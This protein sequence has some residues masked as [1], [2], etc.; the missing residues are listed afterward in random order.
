MRIWSNIDRSFANAQWLD[1]FSDVIIERLDKSVSDHCPQLLKFDQ[2]EVKRR[3]FHFYNV[4]DE[5]EEFVPIVKKEW[6]RVWSANKLKD[7][8]IKCQKLRKPLKQLN[9]RWFL[10]TSERVNNIRQQL[11]EI[12]YYTMRR[13]CDREQLQEEKR[14]MA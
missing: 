6:E 2:R 1:E 3:G 11:K 12:Q 8:W 13:E 4:I 7:I 10:K 5:H 14:L 9:S